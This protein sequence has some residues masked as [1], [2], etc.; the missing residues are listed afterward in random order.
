MGA[1]MFISTPRDWGNV[2]RDRRNHLGM[3]QEELADRVG[4]A[5]QWVVRFESGHAGSARVENLLK[6]MD[7]LDL[8]VEVNA[9]TQSDEAADDDPDP[10]FMD[11]VDP[12]ET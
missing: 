10:M 5:R 8:F 11:I 9:T 7:A 2:V 4:T 6:M 3:T 1:T 12:W